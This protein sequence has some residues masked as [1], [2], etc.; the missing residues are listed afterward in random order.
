MAIPA[1]ARLFVHGFDSPAV[2]LGFNAFNWTHEIAGAGAPELSCNLDLGE[3]WTVGAGSVGTAILYFLTLLTRNF[4][5]IISDGDR[6]KRE[7][8]TRSPIFVNADVTRPKAAVAAG[9]LKGCGVEKIV[10]E[11][12][13]LHESRSW[14]RREAGRP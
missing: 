14:D 13:A 8:I 6:V 7:N 3:I 5:G 10:P 12:V 2:T 11:A 9:Y 1:A 4:S